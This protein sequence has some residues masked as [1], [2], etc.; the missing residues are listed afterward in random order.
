MK[1]PLLVANW[2]MNPTK[3]AKAKEI[4][5]FYDNEN[6]VICPPFVF[7]NEVKET[8]KKASLGAQNCFWE[9]SS[10][11]KG[12]FTGE[13]SGEMLADIGCRFVILGHSERR[14]IFKEDY[15]SIKRKIKITLS[16]GMTPI[17]CIGEKGGEE[18]KQIETIKKQITDSLEKSL[19]KKI[20][21][22]YEP[23]FA[24]GTG[25]PCDSYLAE[26]RKLL[27]KKILEEIVKGGDKTPIL[28]GGSVNSKNAALYI[29]EAGF[30]G[31]LV[32]GASLDKKEFKQIIESLK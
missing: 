8:I 11:K 2:K 12:A 29:K 10:H 32:G 7:L 30:D 18:K 13:I 23:V 27:I 19:V 20:I 22:A 3:L 21:I 16:L 15:L 6:V 4:A 26:K 25:K 1:K 24:I 14:E 5:K 28:Y 17:L 31:L 9:K